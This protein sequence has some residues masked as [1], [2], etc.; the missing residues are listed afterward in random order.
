MQVCQVHRGKQEAVRGEP[1]FVALYENGAL[2]CIDEGQPYIDER[3]CV[4]RAHEV[5]R[6]VACADIATGRPI[7]LGNYVAIQGCDG[8]IVRTISFRD[9][10][11]FA[12]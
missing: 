8:H 5:I 6:D 11:A 9:V 7:D 3:A 2:T 10:I 1:Y 12:D 4:L